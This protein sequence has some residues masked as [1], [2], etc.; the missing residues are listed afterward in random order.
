MKSLILILLFSGFCISCQTKAQ[1]KNSNSTKITKNNNE[2]VRT[3]PDTKQPNSITDEQAD[4]KIGTI[5]SGKQSVCLKIQNANLK[6]GE[7]IQIIMTELPQKS[8]EAEISEQSSCIEENFGYLDAVGITDYLL[9][10]SDQNFL[11]QGYGIGVVTSQK[12]QMDKKFATF[13]IDGDGKAEYFRECT[14]MEGLHLTVWKGKP[15]IG[16][17]IWHAYYGVGYDTVPTCK[18]KDFYGTND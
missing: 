11:S 18:K 17:G 13:D 9:K 6:V 4:S 12:V 1:V 8:V 16:K 2:S 10:S 15:L 3:Q 14:S 5:Q 7:K